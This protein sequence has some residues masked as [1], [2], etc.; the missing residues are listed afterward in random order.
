MSLR[1]GLPPEVPSLA[2]NMAC[3]TGLAAL[4]QS[5]REI[6]CGDAELSLCVGA[7]CPSLVDKE[8]FGPSFYD[9]ECGSEIGATVEALAA[10]RGIDA[11]AMDAWALESHLRAKRA[12]AVAREEIVAFGGLALDDSVL[13]NPAAVSFANAKRLYGG[14]ISGRNTHA[15]VDGAA[16]LVL[17]AQRPDGA[18]GRFVDGASVGVE[19]ARMGL[20]SVPAIRALLK[21]T[22]KTIADIDLFEIN[23]TFA[24]QV[25]MDIGE[26]Q[27]PP[28]KVNVNG[29]AIA[30]GHPFAATG[31]KLVLGLLLEL[32][33]RKLRTGIAAICVGGGIGVAVLVERL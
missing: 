12:K 3:G 30:F 17:G 19:P 18:L 5:A 29:G 16:A 20:A 7:D 33:R 22:G 9:E 1:A 2:M 15:I 23:E 31:G 14:G 26:L 6:A 8:I 13:E 27:I 11:A 21:K 24:A 4:I 32:R 28:E 25:L 10:E